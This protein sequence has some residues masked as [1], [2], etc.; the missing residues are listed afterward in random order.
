MFKSKLMMTSLLVAVTVLL[1]VSNTQ[2]QKK[3]DYDESLYSALEYRSI[4][5]FRGGRSAAVAGVPGDPMT[6]YFGGTGGGVWK[7][8][9]GGQTW[10]PISDKFFGGSIGAVAVSEW[11]PNVIYV[12]G[13]EVTV[14]GNVSHG[15]GMFKSTDAGKTWKNIGLKDSRRIPRIRIHP[16]NP[17]LVY[18]AVLG[19]L[20]GPNE[21]RGVYRSKNGGTSWEKI[22]FVSNEVG[23]VDLAMDPGN[24]RNLFASFWRIKR[25]PSSLESGGEG[26]GIWKSTDGGDNWTEITRN[27]GLPKGTVGISGVTISPVNSDRVW[28]IIEAKDGGV[29]RSDADGVKRKKVNKDRKRPRAGW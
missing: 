22:L 19:H 11:D 18:A 1:F 8:A 28:F 23:A 14:R 20:F 10:T 26:S 29:F 6:F 16:R 21:E 4:G 13:G 15:Y 7:T 3:V 5:P 2:A 24:P 27:E 9:N 25:T 17:D 12:G